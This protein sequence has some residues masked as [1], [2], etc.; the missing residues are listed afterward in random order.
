MLFAVVFF[1]QKGDTALHHACRKQNLEMAKWLAEQMT[2]EAA[3]GLNQA[4]EKVL[5]RMRCF[6]LQINV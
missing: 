2:S 3:L 6:I 1:A 5:Y 4:S